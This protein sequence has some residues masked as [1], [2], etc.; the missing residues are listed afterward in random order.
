MSTSAWIAM[1]EQVRTLSLSRTSPSLPVGHQVRR[2]P[3]CLTL[4]SSEAWSPSFPFE[5]R[6]TGAGHCHPLVDKPHQNPLVPVFAPC[7][8][9][10][11]EKLVFLFI[12]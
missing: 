7:G 2:E 3:G 9:T 8:A 1:P 4:Q 6:R 10:S 12:F 11:M 5:G